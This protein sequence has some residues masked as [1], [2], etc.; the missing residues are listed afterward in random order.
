MTVIEYSIW[1]KATLRSKRLNGC[2]ALG[3]FAQEPFSFQNRHGRKWSRYGLAKFPHRA[4]FPFS[5][6]K[7]ITLLGPNLQQKNKDAALSTRVY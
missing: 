4:L 3:S 2:S 1:E 6:A 5:K 7:R